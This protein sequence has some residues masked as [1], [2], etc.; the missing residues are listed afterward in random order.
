MAVLPAR[1]NG[2]PDASV[3]VVM[4]TLIAKIRN[5]PY[6][7]SIGFAAGRI[8]SANATQRHWAETVASIASRAGQAEQRAEHAETQLKWYT[9]RY[10]ALQQ[11][12]ER[13]EAMLQTRNLSGGFFP[14]A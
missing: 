11:R 8:A 13:L 10:C 5:I 12:A 14:N 7:W 6:A 1:Q 4:R 3:R 2:I 9:D